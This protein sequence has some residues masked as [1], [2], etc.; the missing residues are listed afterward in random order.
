MSRHE[1]A[2]SLIGGTP[3]VRINRA[4]NPEMA[5]LWAK[6]EGANPTHA[7]RDRLAKHL[8][9]VAL[10][11]AA[12]RPGQGL[13]IEATAGRTG[14]SLAM[15]CAIRGVRLV[16]VM[17]RNTPG[18]WRHRLSMTGAEC[19]LT[20]P[21]EGML[22]AHREARRLADEM[23]QAVFLDMFNNPD[24]PAAYP[25]SLAA[26]LI[27]DFADRAL[28]GLVVGVGTG[29]TITG[30]AA[31]L[32]ARWPGIQIWAVEPASSAVLS[33]GTAGPHSIPGIGAGFVP[34][35]LDRGAYDR[36][37]PVSDQ[38]AHDAMRALARAE[39][40]LVDVA[41][42]A[43]FIAARKLAAE[44][45]PSCDVVFLCPSTPLGPLD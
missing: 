22:G 39:G 27:A 40:L 12:V 6:I 28:D 18:D 19:V 35:I 21:G 44:L 13:L 43:C 29:G 36:V 32:R 15:V 10:E 42:G 25:H 5:T 34:S 26:E 2:L 8:V 24:N 33:G 20:D 3:L 45:G 31:P 1:T 17:P 16:L 4:R 38:H 23:E 30:I 7:G 41:S 11:T 37:E 14:L 9:D